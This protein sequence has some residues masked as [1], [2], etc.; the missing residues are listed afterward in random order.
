MEQIERVF[1]VKSDRPVE[2]EKVS[3]DFVTNYRFAGNN[4]DLEIVRIYVFEFFFLEPVSREQFFSTCR[5][6]VHVSVGLSHAGTAHSHTVEFVIGRDGVAR[7][8]ILPDEGL[9]YPIQ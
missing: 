7:Q 2:I 3:S 1:A 9:P 4:V 6:L 8:L 5:S